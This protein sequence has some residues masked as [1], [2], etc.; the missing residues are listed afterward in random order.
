MRTIKEIKM[1]TRFKKITKTFAE[2]Q[3][4]AARKSASIATRR[5]PSCGSLCKT[6]AGNIGTRATCEKCGG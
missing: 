1:N 5:C 2:R 6:F 4:A 3:A